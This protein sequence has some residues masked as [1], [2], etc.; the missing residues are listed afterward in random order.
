VEGAPDA[1][2]PGHAIGGAGWAAPRVWRRGA[3]SPLPRCGGRGRSAAPETVYPV[4]IRACQIR[5][6]YLKVPAR[7]PALPAYPVAVHHERPHPAFQRPLPA[8]GLASVT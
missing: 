5:H 3:A 4:V 1:R 8:A 6:A 7:L 2:L